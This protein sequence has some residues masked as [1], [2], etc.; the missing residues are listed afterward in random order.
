MKDETGIEGKID[1]LA[2]MVAR[3]FTEFRK[4]MKEEFVAVHTELSTKATKDDVAQI[5]R[6]LGKTLDLHQNEV[7]DLARRTKDLEMAVSK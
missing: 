7:D 2:Q 3:E 5:E 6:S 4:D 1:E